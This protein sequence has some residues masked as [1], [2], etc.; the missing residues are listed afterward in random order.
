MH[1]GEAGSHCMMIF[2]VKK[3]CVHWHLQP[4]LWPP[5]ML[6]ATR[7]VLICVF[8]TVT[9][10]L[11]EYFG[12]LCGKSKL[13]P[14]KYFTG[15]A[16]NWNHY[17]LVNRFREQMC[18]ATDYVSLVTRRCQRAVSEGLI[19]CWTGSCQNSWSQQICLAIRGMQPQPSF[20][21]RVL[22]RTYTS[23]HCEEVSS[24]PWGRT[25]CVQNIGV[26]LSEAFFHCEPTDGSQNWIADNI[27]INADLQW[28]VPYSEGYNPIFSFLSFTVR[29]VT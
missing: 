20:Q 16:P 19:F 27:F 8:F 13:N 5:W 25:V 22:A 11:K 23:Q 18:C 7:E 4:L 26:R 1:D 14:N 15:P 24:G 29:N 17:Q 6:L 9:L 28:L 2:S 3:Y 10:T 12:R 21:E